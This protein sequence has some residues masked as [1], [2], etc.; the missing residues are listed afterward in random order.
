[1]NNTPLINHTELINRKDWKSFNDKFQ[2]IHIPFKDIFHTP[3]SNKQNHK[4]IIYKY[5]TNDGNHVLYSDY[6]I[7][8]VKN[9]FQ[10]NEGEYIRYREEAVLYDN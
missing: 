10:I 6:T 1:M 5:V 8:F 9:G 3:N 4:R 2:Y 7:L